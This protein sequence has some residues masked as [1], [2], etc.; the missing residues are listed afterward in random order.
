MLIACPNCATPYQADLAVPGAA[1]RAVRCARCRQLWFAYDPAPFAAIVQTHRSE[2]A[3][4]MNGEEAVAMMATPESKPECA[5]SAPAPQPDEPV[6]ELTAIRPLTPADPAG[7]KP[8]RERGSIAAAARAAGAKRARRSLLP[9]ALVPLIALD[10]ALIAWRSE[11]VRIA[12]QTA[13]V[14]PP[15]ACP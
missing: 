10:L 15:S 1:G 12:P 4:L 3:A 7:P 5:G 13:P 8:R 2:V 14:S 11:V 6:I 9:L